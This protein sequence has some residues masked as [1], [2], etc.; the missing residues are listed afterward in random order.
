MSAFRKI[1]KIVVLVFVANALYQFVPPYYRYVRFKDGVHETALFSQRMQD[2]EIV[3][4]VMALA[5]RL[6][7]PLDRE[8]VQIQHQGTRVVIDASYLEPMTFVPGNTYQW[9]FNVGAD[10]LHGKAPDQQIP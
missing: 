1:V 7:V 6:H 5:D 9:Q 10:V 4:R 2:V 8:S 3:D